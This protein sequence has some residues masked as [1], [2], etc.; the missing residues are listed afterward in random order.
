MPLQFSSVKERYMR[1]KYNRLKTLYLSYVFL[2]CFYFYYIIL[3]VCMFTYIYIYT[4]KY[5]NVLYYPPPQQYGGFNNTLEPEIYVESMNK[6][7]K[8]LNK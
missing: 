8:E 6:I 3:V 2:F 1:E 5:K 4:F 7:L